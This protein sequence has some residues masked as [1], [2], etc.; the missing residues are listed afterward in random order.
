MN[1]VTVKEVTAWE[2]LDS[3]GTPTVGC[4]VRLT[5]GSR[6]TVI[7][8]SGASTGS[9]EVHE[10]R[11]GGERYGGRGVQ[12][13]VG[14]VNNE[15]AASVRGLPADDQHLIDSALRDADGTTD[16]SRLG[17]NAV[18]AISIACA[19]A[20]ADAHREPLHRFVA[21]PGTP[22][23]PLP[24]VNILSGGAHAGF[25]V[26]LQD[27]LAVPV[28]AE[29]FSVAIE[30]VWRVRRAAAELLEEQGLPAALVADE[31]GLGP[32]LPTNRSAIELVTRAIER[33]NL[34]PGD[35]VSIAIDV[36]SGQ[37]LGPT[38]Y[39]L[40]SE[41]RTLSPEDLITEIS[42]WAESFPV[43]SVED[44]VAEDDWDAWDVASTR[45]GGLQL[46]GDD[47]FATDLERV[48]RGIER[49]IANA[50]LVKPNQTGTLSSALRV[51]EEAQRSGYATVLS[52]RSGDTEDSWLADLAVGWRARQ[53]KVGSTT[54]SERTAKW[55]RL[56]QIESELGRAVEFAGGAALN[57]NP[58]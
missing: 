23:L 44:P 4:V 43:V 28:G 49:G 10:L 32:P 38:G 22:V 3:R 42:T 17:G 33:A 58:R 47:L 21:R 48:L 11:D 57:L 9:H 20:A 6:G 26:D 19:L 40:A 27:V 53:I 45:L 51:V 24:M 55:N 2:A 46:V 30:W 13:A 34:V 50:V 54:R 37:L 12:Q 56:L 36:A 7:V 18:L 35:D 16:L 25:A 8:P 15:L 31:G 39:R 41:D 29:S 5:G 14:H 1:A 52:A